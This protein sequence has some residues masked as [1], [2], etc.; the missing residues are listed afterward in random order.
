MLN[1]QKTSMKQ[2]FILVLVT[3][4]YTHKFFSSFISVV[5]T[6]LQSVFRFD[7]VMSLSEMNIIIENIQLILFKVHFCGMRNMFI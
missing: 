4:A 1:F 2:K 7:S 3:S 6:F 5:G